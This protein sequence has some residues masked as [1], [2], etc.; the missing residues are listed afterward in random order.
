MPKDHT[1]DVKCQGGDSV[2]L[3]ALQDGSDKNWQTDRPLSVLVDEVEE[4][5]RRPTSVDSWPL[6]NSNRS[7]L[8]MEQGKVYHSK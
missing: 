8:D 3:R 4:E 2:G 1:Y 7:V 6:H 5:N